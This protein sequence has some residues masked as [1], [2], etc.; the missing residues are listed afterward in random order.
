MNRKV[1]GHAF[2]NL[3]VADDLQITMPVQI[4]VKVIDLVSRRVLVGRRDDRERHIAIAA[5]R[6]GGTNGEL[7]TRS[8]CETANGVVAFDIST[9]TSLRRETRGLARLAFLA[10]R[11]FF[12]V[13]RCAARNGRRAR[14][15]V[16]PACLTE[17]NRIVGNAQVALARQIDV[18]PAAAVIAVFVVGNA[19]K[20]K[21]LVAIDFDAFEIVVDNEVRPVIRRAD[22]VIVNTLSDIARFTLDRA[23]LRNI[24]FNVFARRSAVDAHVARNEGDQFIRRRHGRVHVIDIVLREDRVRIHRLTAGI[25]IDHETFGEI[26]R[27]RVEVR[28]LAARARHAEA[29]DRKD[30]A[31]TKRENFVAEVSN[32]GHFRIGA[33]AKHECARL[34]L[35]KL[36]ERAV[37]SVLIEFD[38]PIVER[39]RARKARKRIFSKEK[40]LI[41]AAFASEREFARAS[42][43]ALPGPVRSVRAFGEREL[44]LAGK[45]NV[46]LADVAV[47]V[48]RSLNEAVLGNREAAR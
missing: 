41:V 32:A 30:A 28:G 1:R 11:A 48:A 19:G 12:R 34:P 9:G 36:S 16:P 45:R 8:K 42:K 5:H 20:N 26:K 47:D 10:K 37:V 35:G 21:R 15:V 3:T 27:L 6:V 25:E 17:A 13:E 7:S 31:R 29:V 4:A 24:E 14:V 18:K 44:G 39:D 46:A 33:V 2:V 40:R 38:R 22:G 23:R 43:V